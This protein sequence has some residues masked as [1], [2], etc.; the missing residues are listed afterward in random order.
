MVPTLAQWKTQTSSDLEARRGNVSNPEILTV[1]NHL[2]LY[3]QNGSWAVSVAPLFDILTTIEQWDKRR[4]G[5]RAQRSDPLQD[6]LRDQDSKRSVAFE[7]LWDEVT[8]ELR[9]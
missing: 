5:Q 4:R 6:K 8:D 1:D 3:N 9:S 7:R 2:A